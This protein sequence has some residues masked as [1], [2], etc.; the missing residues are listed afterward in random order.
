MAPS[1]PVL[2]ATIGAAHGVRGEVRVRSYTAD[3]L[4]FAAYGPT[5]ADDG[6]VFE[7]ERV[8]PGKGVVIAKFRGVD[9]RDAA[10]G[11]N[12][13]SL[14][15]ERAVLPRV[16]Q[17]EFYHA[18]LIGMRAVGPSGTSLGS[19]TAVHDFGAGDILEIAPR[20]GPPVLVPFTR[21]HVPEVDLAAGVV[22][23]DPPQEAA[24]P[25]VEEQGA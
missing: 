4:A 6:R 12:G 16:D 22:V 11:L 19:V 17:D 20:S 15:V 3:A 8:R 21:D 18:D 7:V 9:D 10:E 14:Y 13:L 23:V 2:L 24:A 25:A 5:R 1:N